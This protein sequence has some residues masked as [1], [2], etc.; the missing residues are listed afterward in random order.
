MEEVERECEES[1]LKMEEAVEEEAEA[2]EKENEKQPLF[3]GG[4]GCRPSHR[5][6]SPPAGTFQVRIRRLKSRECHRLRRQRS[7]P[8]YILVS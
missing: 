2:A 3:P 7:M 4:Q 1:I 5:R 6:C 8:C